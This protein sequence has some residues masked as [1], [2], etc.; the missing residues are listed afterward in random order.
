MISVLTLTYNRLPLLRQA[1]QSVLVQPGDWEMVVLNDQVSVTYV[2]HDPRVRVFNLKRRA[3]S[4]IRKLFLGFDLCHGDH[5]YR[6][7]DDD[8]LIPGALD[9][10]R[11]NLTDWAD[12]HR[13]AVHESWE[14]DRY[15]GL[16]GAVNTGNVYRRDWVRGLRIPKA[17]FGSQGEDAWLTYHAGGRIHE[18]P[19]PTMRYRWGCNTYHV[20]G[21]G[22]LPTDKMDDWLQT[23]ITPE[24]G[25]H[26][27]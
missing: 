6:L 23:L 26:V 4:I 27:I 22:K 15:L 5:V 7:D 13:S 14:D 8:L 17:D 24:T 20:S 21:M 3:P 10:V 9:T 12:I 18:F 19:E 2:G 16:K 11:R 25:E 1:V